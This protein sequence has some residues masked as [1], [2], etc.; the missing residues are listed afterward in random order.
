MAS[1]TSGSGSADQP[2]ISVSPARNRPARDG[3]AIRSALVADLG[4][5][6]LHQFV[7]RATDLMVGLLH[8]GGVEIAANL[9]ENVALP[10][11]FEVGGDDR[12]RI[13]LGVRAGLAE[14]AR[15]SQPDELVSSR[16][17]LELKLGVM[18][19]LVLEGVLALVE[20]GHQRLPCGACGEK[21]PCISS[22]RA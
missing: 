12:L 10:G 4:D 17:G 5:R 13:G 16:L 9:G 18:R 19:E 1:A 7:H 8:A 22:A 21:W 11:L 15:R 20:G 2:D 6:G 14:K 3:I